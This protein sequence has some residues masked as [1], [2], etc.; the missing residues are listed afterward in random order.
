MKRVSS[1]LYIL[2]NFNNLQWLYQPFLSIIPIKRGWVLSKKNPG[3]RGPGFSCG[4]IG[5][6][7]RDTILSYTRFPGVPLKPLEHLSNQF[8]ISSMMIYVN[9]G[10]NIGIIFRISFLLGKILH[11][12]W[13]ICISLMNL[14]FVDESV[15]CR[16]VCISCWICI[17]LANLY[18]GVESMICWWI[19]ILLRNLCFGANLY[20]VGGFALPWWTC[21]KCDDPKRIVPLCELNIWNR[22]PSGVRIKRRRVWLLTRPHFM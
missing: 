13:W 4:E 3:P 16:C 1:N 15:I 22:T 8:C 5:I 19:F 9:E 12:R 17:L 18:F 7:T 10:A 14:H 11:F 20:F 6:R 21:K 2:Q